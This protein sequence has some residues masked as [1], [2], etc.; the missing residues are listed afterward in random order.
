MVVGQ[1]IHVAIS[2][3]ALVIALIAF[4]EVRALRKQLSA[5]QS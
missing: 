3:A 2:I 5:N 4:S 1:T